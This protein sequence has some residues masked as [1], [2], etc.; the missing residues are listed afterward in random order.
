[1]FRDRRTP[2][3]R[4]PAEDEIVGSRR[5]VVAVDVE[6]VPLPMGGRHAEAVVMTFQSQPRA[7]LVNAN[8][9]ISHAFFVVLPRPCGATNLPG[10]S[11]GPSSPP[12]R[13]SSRPFSSTNEIRGPMF[14]W[15]RF[16]GMEG[17]SS[18]IANS[19]V[20]PRQQ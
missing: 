2:G 9:R 1:M 17:P 3:G 12:R 14:G 15:A 7:S 19:G 8:H 10:S 13:A 4:D 18:P 6:R 16:T 11:P 20:F 5:A